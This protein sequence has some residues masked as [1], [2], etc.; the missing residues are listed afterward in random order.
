MANLL[1]SNVESLKVKLVIRRGVVSNNSCVVWRG[2]YQPFTKIHYECIKGLYETYISKLEE[3]PWLVLCVIRG[4]ETLSRKYGLEGADREIRG[5]LSH[6]RL[7]PFSNPLPISACVVSIKEGL[8][9]FLLNDAEAVS[10]E[11]KMFVRTKI[12]IIPIPKKFVSMVE[13]LCQIDISD[14]YVSRDQSEYR[15]DSD[16]Q[17]RDYITEDLEGFISALV[18]ESIHFEKHQL[19]LPNF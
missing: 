9:Y 11:F 6:I 14:R 18:K 13:F 15:S 16:N 8:E 12:L 1:R 10:E 2:R 17:V 4:Y 19:V 7:E 5:N 3:E